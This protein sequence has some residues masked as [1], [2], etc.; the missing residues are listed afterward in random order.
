MTLY[1]NLNSCSLGSGSEVGEKGEKEKSRER[2]SSGERALPFFYFLRFPPLRKICEIMGLVGMS[3]KTKI[4]MFSAK[5]SA[6]WGKLVRR[7][8]PRFARITPY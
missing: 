1:K 8:K 5:K 2:K 4:K 7:Y 3:R 6:F